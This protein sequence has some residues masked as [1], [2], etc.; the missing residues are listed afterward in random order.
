MVDTDLA[1]DPATELP[2]RSVT[3][4]VVT[5]GA[6]PGSSPASA[7]SVV[8][9]ADGAAGTDECPV[10]VGDDVAGVLLFPELPWYCSDGEAMPDAEDD[11]L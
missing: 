2:S 9:P 5:A 11:L 10:T 3:A 6:V 7:T 4:A 8:E 1:G